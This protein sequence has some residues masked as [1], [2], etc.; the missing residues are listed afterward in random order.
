MTLFLDQTLCVTKCVTLW[1]PDTLSVPVLFPFEYTV[2]Y[3]L[4]PTRGWP[5]S[6]HPFFWCLWVHS[7]LSSQS[8]HRLFRWLWGHNGFLLPL[9]SLKRPSTRLWGYSSRRF[10]HSLWRVSFGGCEDTMGYCYHSLCSFPFGGDEDRGHTQTSPSDHVLPNM[11]ED[12]L[13]IIHSWVQ[14]LGICRSLLI[15][16]SRRIPLTSDKYS[17][18]HCSDFIVNTVGEYIVNT[19]GLT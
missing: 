14:W 4:S 11:N 13:G 17:R 6:L 19:I 18:C 16:I 10:Q 15:L 5:H 3:R 9:Q 7:S 12:L 1:G 8:S 2:W